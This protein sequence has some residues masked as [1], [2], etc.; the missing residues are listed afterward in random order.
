MVAAIRQAFVSAFDSALPPTCPLCRR[1]VQAGPGLCQPCWSRL[2]PIERPWCER[3]GTPMTYDLGP[4]ALSAAAV[5]DPPPY[6]RAR[7]AVCYTEAAAELVGAF[8]YADRSDLAPLLAAMMLR[9][10][11]DLALEADVLVPV[12][13]HRFRL[14]SRRYNQSALLA[15]E[16][17]RRTGRPHRPRLL[18]RRRPTPR[19]VGLSREGRLANVKGAFAV[20]KSLRRHVKGRRV[21]LVDDVVTTGATVEAATRALLRAGAAS[22]DVVAFARVVPGVG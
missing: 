10:S 15:A 14:F 13:L 3:L 16:L 2:V 12:P 17:G 5:A 9:V 4:G 19:Q 6:V 22:V 20:P 21:L 1:R 18:V 11:K 8:K 7:A